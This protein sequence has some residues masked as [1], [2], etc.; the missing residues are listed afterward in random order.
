M[1]KRAIISVSS[2]QKSDENDVIEVVTPGDFYEKDGSY[3]AVYKET[4]ISGMEGTTT[5]LKISDDKFSIIRMGSTSAKMEFD[6]KAKS[7]SM[8]NTPYGT[9]ELKIETKTLSVNVGEKGGDIQVN[10]NLTVSGQTPNNTQ[11]KIN[12]KA[13][14]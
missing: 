11:L 6:K 2:K 10:Y 3:Y 8:Y 1:K 13:Q 4:E 7:V 12:I 14:E 9:L 5:T